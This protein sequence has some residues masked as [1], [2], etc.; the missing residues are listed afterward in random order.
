MSRL[1]TSVLIAL[2]LWGGAAFAWSPFS[3]KKQL[4]ECSSYEAAQ[5]CLSS[6]K[7]MS[8]KVE[9]KVNVTNKSVMMLA[10]IDGNKSSSMLDNCMVVDDGNWS[11]SSESRLGNVS[12][13]F[14]LWSMTN[15]KLFWVQA[16]NIRGVDST[17]FMCTK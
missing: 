15:N 2:S 10:D 14:S 12:S 11:C 13:S 6:C 5:V 3:S 8:W 9:F 17:M 7:P 1:K 16:S 4:F